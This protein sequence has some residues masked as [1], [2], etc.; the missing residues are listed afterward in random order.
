LLLAYQDS[1]AIQFK[2]GYWQS[3]THTWS[4]SN[5][6]QISTGSGFAHNYSPSICRTDSYYPVVC[7]IGDIREESGG[8]GITKINSTNEAGSPEPQAIV[9]VGSF[10]GSNWGSFLKLGDNVISTNNNSLPESSNQETII[11]WSEGSNPNFNSKWVRRAIT[12]CTDAHALSSNGKQIQVSNGTSYENIG[13]VVFTTATTPYNLALTT[14]DFN[15]EFTGGGITKIKDNIELGYGREG[16]IVK[17]GIE[18][19]FDIGDVIVSDSAIKFIS[20]PDTIAYNSAAELNNLVRTEA[21][22]LD[23]SSEFYFTDFYYVLHKEEADSLL[24]EDDMVNFKAEL[25]SEQTG[26]V[27]GTFDDITYT[28]QQLEGYDNVSYRVDCSNITSGNY[29]LR[30]V[31]S[32]QGGAGYY[33]GNVQNGSEELNKK[34]YNQINFDGSKLPVTYDLSQNYPN[35]FNPT[36]TINYQIP[37]S[38]FVTLKVYDILGKEIATLVNEQKIQGRYSVKFNASS[39]AGGLASGVYIYQIRAN[40]YVSSKK[41]L[42]LK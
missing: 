27:V 41:M 18:F 34:N 19:L 36:T 29:Y 16:I 25:V 6:S 15:Q 40:D 30:L 39:A 20:C 12:G 22:N 2:Y 21:F 14:T 28:K 42:L 13:G 23:P 9:R 26:E 10:T 38:E 37:R 1:Y 5:E 24:T 32:V 3:H 4:F 33:L 35:P 8:G 11:T 7:W 31:T 17:N